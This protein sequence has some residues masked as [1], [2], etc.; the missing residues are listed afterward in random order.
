MG[1]KDNPSNCVLCSSKTEQVIWSHEVDCV[2][3]VNVSKKMVLSY[4]RNLVPT[5]FTCANAIRAPIKF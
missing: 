5:S 2:C 1:C 3:V 4:N